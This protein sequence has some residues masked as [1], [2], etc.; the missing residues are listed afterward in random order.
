MPKK[1]ARK[2]VVTIIDVPANNI[3]NRSN[4]SDV[5][6]NRSCV[7]RTEQ[8]MM[9]GKYMIMNEINVDK[10]RGTSVTI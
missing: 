3:K 5:F 2:W 10:I 9:P 1:E 4:I 7:N 8:I 6:V